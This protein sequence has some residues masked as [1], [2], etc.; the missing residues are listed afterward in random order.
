MRNS[1]TFLC[2]AA[3]AASACTFFDAHAG[4]ISLNF[5]AAGGTVLDSAGVGSGFTARLP[6]TSGPANDPLLRL[7]AAN[8]ELELTTS[9]SDFNG[10]SGLTAISAPGVKLSSLGYTGAEDFVVRAVF[11]PIINLEPIDQIGV[12]IGMDASTLTRAGVIRFDSPE[13]LAVHTTAS[14]DNNGRF[15]GFGLVVSDGLEVIIRRTAGD[16]EYFIDGVYWHPNTVN[17]GSGFESDPD[18]SVGSPNLNAA[19]DLYVGVFAITVFNANAKTAL[20]DSFEVTV[21]PEPA[22]LLLAGSIAAMATRWRRR[23]GDDR[24]RSAA[25]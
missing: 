6:G 21:V 11:K 23:S 8:S 13:Y 22:S 18:G 20:V 7:D 17:N 1:T 5:D 15:F 25:G 3:A 16:W 19:S 12:Y 24:R 9:Q 4:S 10:G 14:V 2:L